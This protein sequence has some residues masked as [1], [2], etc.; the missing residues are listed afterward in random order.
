MVMIQENYRIYTLIK[1]A[2]D[3]FEGQLSLN[4]VHFFLSLFLAEFHKFS[5]VAKSKH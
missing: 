5:S 2:T 4:C 1:T 3:H